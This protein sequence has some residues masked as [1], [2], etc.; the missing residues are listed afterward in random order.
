MG[1]ASAYLGSMTLA[2]ALVEEEPHTDTGII[3]IVPSF[4][5]P[6]IVSLLN[7]LVKCQQPGCKVE[8]L[9]GINAP[10]DASERQL[11]QNN[12]ISRL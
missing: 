11:E 6:D 7:S 2:R 9:I 12:L 5:E 10:P 4:D 8:V 3:L 1:F